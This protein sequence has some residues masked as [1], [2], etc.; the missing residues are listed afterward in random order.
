ME[1][2]EKMNFLK[3]REISKMICLIQESNIYFE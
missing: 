2:Y 1:E 3:I